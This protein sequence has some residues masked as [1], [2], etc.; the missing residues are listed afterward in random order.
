[1]LWWEQIEQTD[2]ANDTYTIGAGKNAQT[3]NAVAIGF[4]IE[5]TNDVQTESA[6]MYIWQ[7]AINGVAF[8]GR[9]WNDFFCALAVVREK[10]SGDIIIGIHNMGFEMSFL[11]PRLHIADMLTRVFAKSKNAPLE[12]VTKNGFIFRDTMAITNMSLAA[13]AKSYCTTQKLVG[14]LDYSVKRN[15]R[16]QLTAQELAYCENDVL[17][18]SE[19]M[20]YLH[21]EYSAHKQR[22]PLTSTGIV[23]RMIKQGLRGWAYKNACKQVKSLYPKTAAEY[24]YTIKYLFRGGFCHA[25]T[26][27][28]NQTLHNVHSHDL[29]SAYP[30]E[31]AHRLYPMTPF[32]KIKPENALPSIK[33]GLAVIMICEF[34]DITATGAHVLESRHKAISTVGAEWENGRLYHA[35]K[36][37]VMIT[38]VDYLIYKMFYKWG[39]MRIL[40][41]KTSAKDF[42]P[43]YL[44][45]PLFTVFSE[46]ERIGKLTKSD[47]ENNELRQLYQSTKCKLNSFYGMC[48][49]RLNLTSWEYDGEWTEI[50]NSSY[51][52]EISN[53]V[54]SP[55]WGIYI[56]AYTR[57]TICTA[58]NAIGDCAYYSDTDSIK[59]SAPFD[60]FNTFNQ[61]IERINKSMCEKWELDYNIFKKLGILDYENTY[62]RFK[63]LGAKRYLVENENS[64]E[65]TV[66]GLPK[67]VFKSRYMHKIDGEW[68]YISTD[69]A[70][71]AFTEF[72]PDLAFE[73]SGKNAHKYN[74]ETSA[75]IC[76][77]IMHEYGS[78]YIYSV[79]FKM[80]VESSFLLAISKRQGVAQYDN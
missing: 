21:N 61:K 36:L 5:T 50:V 52:D 68:Q 63:T 13:L 79:S 80:T 37:T 19:F 43:D 72:A 12:I 48:V 32:K 30:A 57:L 34:T 60:Y 46:K 51:E 1:M 67:T 55:Y 66:A 76:G 20:R 26:A 70:D 8:Y 10:F 73:I 53:S 15:S 41:A 2:F 14:D 4:D 58:I 9:T 71:R 75:D 27:I 16:T 22:I 65:C 42:L 17:I 78:C 62:K 56:T 7:M 18:L 38:D 29:K 25:Q 44:L 28:C 64:I 11:L 74:G 59:H 24:D 45:K 33:R 35:D 39:E 54:L 77:E 69:G 47:P 3:V 23:R 49:A 40:G 6:Y 31:M